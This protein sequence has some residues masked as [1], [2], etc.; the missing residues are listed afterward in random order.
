MDGSPV[1]GEGGYSSSRD[2]DRDLQST[3]GLESR[4]DSDLHAADDLP[5]LPELEGGPPGRLR[6]L[7][8]SEVCYRP[9][10]AVVV[11]LSL[12]YII[13]GDAAHF[14]R[15]TVKFNLM[16]GDASDALL[17]VR[18]RAVC[19]GPCVREL[20]SLHGAARR[21]RC[22]LRSSAPTPPPPLPHPTDTHL[23]SPPR[24]RGCG[25]PTP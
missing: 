19:V 4:R 17:S 9:K 21:A 22:R 25:R 18:V 16:R 3:S 23:P 2:D 1:V 7:C 10:D 15:R 5:S 20:Y 11:A 8:M 13:P 24:P 12:F 6:G 14:R